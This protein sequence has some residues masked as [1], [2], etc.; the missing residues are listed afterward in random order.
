MFLKNTII[1]ASDNFIAAVYQYICFILTVTFKVILKYKN[2]S[3]LK[4]FFVR[5]YMLAKHR[6]S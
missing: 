1:A 6:N 2:S 5:E 3:R 4:Q